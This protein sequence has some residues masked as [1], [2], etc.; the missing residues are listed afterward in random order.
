[1]KDVSGDYL[2]VIDKNISIIFSL[3]NWN[4]HAGKF[5]QHTV[6]KWKQI[7]IDDLKDCEV[8]LKINFKFFLDYCLELLLSGVF[9]LSSM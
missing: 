9:I 5:F 3:K 1:M 8:V 4:I 6:F 7:Y 2:E